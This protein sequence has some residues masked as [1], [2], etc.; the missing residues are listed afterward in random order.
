MSTQLIPIISDNNV[1][2]GFDS[3]DVD[4][5]AQCACIASCLQED[6]SI[7]VVSVSICKECLRLPNDNR[8]CNRMRDE[9]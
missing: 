4:A 7:R 1:I 8:E 2:M 5:C 6:G 9:G 3:A